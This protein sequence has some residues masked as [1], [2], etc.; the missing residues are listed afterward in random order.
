M[1]E[2]VSRFEDLPL[3]GSPS[4]LEFL[5]GFNGQ[6]VENATKILKINQP[7]D[8]R[9]TNVEDDSGK[10]VFSL[11]VDPLS[12]KGETELL[13]DKGKIIAACEREL[14][15][16]TGYITVTENGTKMV[17][18]TLTR[19]LRQKENTMYLYIHSP[20]VPLE[21]AKKTYFQRIQPALYIEGDILLK[22]YDIVAGDIKVDPIKL[23]KVTYYKEESSREETKKQMRTG[24]N[25]RQAMKDSG[26]FFLHVGRNVDHAFMALVALLLDD[27]FDDQDNA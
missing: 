20:R 18:A 27:L 15:E 8:A 16:K 26:H 11:Q 19:L 21:E 1:G 17:V 14:Y 2:T 6:F 25:I 24:G 5:H 13:D 7:W 4:E 10:L 9:C 12:T 22:N 23:A 3:Q